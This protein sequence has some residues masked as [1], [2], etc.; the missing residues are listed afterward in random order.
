VTAICFGF[1]RIFFVLKLIAM[2]TEE[3]LRLATQLL[4]LIRK[5][6]LSQKEAGVKCGISQQVM[7]DLVNGK[8]AFDIEIFKKLSKGFGTVDFLLAYEGP[9]I[10]QP[11][12]KTPTEV[13]KDVQ[14]INEIVH[15]IHGNEIQII[16]LRFERESEKLEQKVKA[17]QQ[18]VVDA[19]KKLENSI[20]SESI[21]SN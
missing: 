19:M 10:D 12:G 8:R 17:L 1:F 13:L 15:F 9:V 6:N 7:S 16:M 3:D 14:E 2:I 20:D 5:N 11:S 18:M 4:K 21:D